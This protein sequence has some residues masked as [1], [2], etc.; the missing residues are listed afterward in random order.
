MKEIS[1]LNIT[2][3]R[4]LFEEAIELI[5]GGVSGREK[6]SRLYRRRISDLS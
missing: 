6:A 2:N 3:S 1:K 4:E 5:P